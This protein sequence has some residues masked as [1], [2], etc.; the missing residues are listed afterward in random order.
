MRCSRSA[1]AALALAAALVPASA[2]AGEGNRWRIA[3]A[4]PCAEAT[5]PAP[6]PGGRC[7]GGSAR[8]RFDPVDVAAEGRVTEGAPPEPADFSGPG[9]CADP[10][11]PCGPIEPTRVADREPP[12]PSATPPPPASGPAAPP[13]GGIPTPPAPTPATPPVGAPPPPPPPPPAPP[14]PE[15]PGVVEPPTGPGTLP[16][17]P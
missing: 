7:A 17:L 10:S 14:A 13:T 16:G 1:L 4:G 9:S 6:C 3:P 15:P 2:G 11:T 8:S 5:L 12:V